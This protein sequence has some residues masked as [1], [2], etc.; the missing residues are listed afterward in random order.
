MVAPF[1]A[2]TKRECFGPLAAADGHTKGAQETGASRL[3]RRMRAGAA[4]KSRGDEVG[5]E[6]S[7]TMD[8]AE[9]VAHGASQHKGRPSCL[10]STPG[11]R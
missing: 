4:T 6:R 3:C 5:A 1:A 2:G 7:S 11:R 10:C 8:G 9:S